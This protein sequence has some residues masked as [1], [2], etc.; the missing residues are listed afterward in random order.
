VYGLGAMFVNAVTGLRQAVEERRRIARELHDSL[1]H[2]ISLIKVQAGIAVHLARQR[3]E[4]VPDTLLAIQEASSDAMRE[5]RATLHVLRDQEEESPGSGLDRLGDLIG[6]ARSAGLPAALTIS[7]EARALPGDVERSAY[8]IVQEA[9][10][11]AARHA[12]GGSAL[13]QISYRP[14][15]LSVRI[16][17]D[18][19]AT[20]DAPPEPGIGLTGM[21]ER[22]TALGGRLRAG[23]RREG[24]FTVEAE[25]P[26]RTRHTGIPHRPRTALAQLS[27]RTG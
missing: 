24:G 1:T 7:G 8:R 23:P 18:G 10:T 20:P 2:N 15:T 13:V 11:N 5:L 9:L 6:R 22:V 14:D 19:R 3:G 26:V 27:G 21:R 12:G 25:L 4:P 17:D 16:D